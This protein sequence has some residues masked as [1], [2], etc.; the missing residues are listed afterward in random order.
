MYIVAIFVLGNMKAKTEF[1]Q[2]DIYC[3]H[4]FMVGGRADLN[5]C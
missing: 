4:G 1:K 2:G 3:L 5:V